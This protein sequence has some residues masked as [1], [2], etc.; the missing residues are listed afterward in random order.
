MA[1]VRAAYDALPPSMK[2][3]PN[4]TFSR[5]YFAICARDFAAAE[6]IVRKSPNEEI[7]FFG[8]VLVPCQIA[9][10]WL[11][12]LQGNHPTME[13]FGAAREQLYRKVEADPSNPPLMTA[14]AFADVFLG[15]KE[16]SIQEGQRAM[17][18]R[19]ISEDAVEGPTIAFFV[20]MVYASANQLDLAFEQLD[21]LIKIPGL[22]AYGDLKTDPGWDPLRKDPRFDKL[23]AE[24]AP[25]D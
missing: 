12:F 8:G 9:T 18:M 19:P 4:M 6:E 21:I 5:A 20:A 15:R 16:E 10:L 17:E 22:I 7:S 25:R 14:L 2:D 3:D 13:Q 23:L 24:L 1:S 11:E